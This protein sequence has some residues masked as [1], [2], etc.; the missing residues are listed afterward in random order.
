[1]ALKPEELTQIGVLTWLKLQ[2]PRVSQ[3]VVK[4]DNEGRRSIGGHVKA[5]KMGL[6]VGA[7]DLF[8]AW[9]TRTYHGLWL[10]VK[11]DKWKPYHTKK[12]RLENQKAFLEKMQRRGYC[13]VLG[14]GFDNCK[15]IINNYLNS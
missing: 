12:D 5:K 3:C 9:P 15:Q 6:H 1:M 10:E 11:P 13:A 2:H 14:V 7:A 4:I 8:I